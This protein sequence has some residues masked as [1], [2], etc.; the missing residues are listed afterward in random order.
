MKQSWNVLSFLSQK[1]MP[2]TALF[3]QAPLKLVCPHEF[4]L[5]C[6]VGI[7]FIPTSVTTAEQ[8]YGGKAF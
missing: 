6:F 1:T 4:A 3:N 5:S 8:E 2:A 7:S